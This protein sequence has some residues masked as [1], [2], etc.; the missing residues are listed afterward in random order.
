MLQK[1]VPFVLNLAICSLS[2]LRV[3]PVTRVHLGTTSSPLIQ[4]RCFGSLHSWRARRSG[5]RS[6]SRTSCPPFRLTAHPL[7]LRLASTMTSRVS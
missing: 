6:R 1:G 7:R 2:F 3:Q 5:M 4:W